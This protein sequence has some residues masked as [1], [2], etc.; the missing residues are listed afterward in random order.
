MTTKTN[1]IFLD[2]D[3]VLTTQRTWHAVDK[4]QGKDIWSSCDPT[5]L[6]LLNLLCEQTQSLVVLSTTWRLYDPKDLPNG[7]SAQ[8]NLKDWGF[9]GKFH[10]DYKTPDL[11]YKT[12]NSEIYKWMTINHDSVVN[13]CSLDDMVLKN[14]TNPVL[15]N[16]D[17]GFSWSNFCQAKNFLSGGG[18]SPQRFLEKGTDL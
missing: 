5:A 2:F 4:P 11:I 10:Q 8:D 14:I 12:R 3:G 7:L 16:D 9:T 6:K 1:I 18:S 17:C 15:V 13:Y